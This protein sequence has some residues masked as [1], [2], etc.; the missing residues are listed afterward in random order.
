MRHLTDPRRA[1]HRG[2][3]PGTR[4][5]AGLTLVEMMVAIAI[6]AL[7]MV[8]AGPYFGDYIVNARLRENGHLLLTEALLAQSEAVKRNNRVRL[9]VTGTTLQVQDASGASPVTLRTRSF[10]GNVSVSADATVE[11]AGDGRLS[12]WPTGATIALQSSAVTCSEEQRC[13]SVIIEA[14]GAIRLCGNKLSCS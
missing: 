1:P 13:P 11:F 9:V 8:S 14:G 3:P 7:L 12:S 6:A 2:Q 4:R 5:Q 10:G